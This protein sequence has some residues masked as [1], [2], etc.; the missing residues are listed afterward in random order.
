[1]L[2]AGGDETLLPYAVDDA[3]SRHRIEQVAPLERELMQLGLHR[4]RLEAEYARMPLSAGRTVAERKEKALLEARLGEIKLQMN[5]VKA[6]LRA[7][8]PMRR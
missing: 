6:R 7:L 5:Q 2:P 4:D 1:V 3:V 8:Q